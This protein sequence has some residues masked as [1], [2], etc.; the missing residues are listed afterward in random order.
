MTLF[1]EAANTGQSWLFLVKSRFADTADCRCEVLL[2]YET[3]RG[4]F[5][6]EYMSVRKVKIEM[7]NRIIEQVS[8]LKYFGNM[9]SDHLKDTDIKLQAYNKLNGVIKRNFGKQMTTETKLKL[10]NISS[11]PA[12]KYGS[13]TWVMNKRDTQ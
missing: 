4:Q 12:L 2:R 10:H 13:E 8:D 3:K 1:R 11:K 6:I 5:E 7:E 9:F